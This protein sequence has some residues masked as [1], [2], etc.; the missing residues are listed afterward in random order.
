MI[1]TNDSL[2]VKEIL[3]AAGPFI[4]SVIDT[5]VTPKLENL[6]KRFSQDYNKYHVPTEEHFSEYFYRTYK[7]VSIINTLVFNNSQRF[8]KDI[9]LPLTLI[10][11]TEKK[12]IKYKMN[13][14]PSHLL[15]NYEKLLIT[16]NAGMGKSTLVKKCF[17][18]Q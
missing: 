1:E 2:P 11:K 12:E 4:K 14:F 15:N 13:S 9:Y 18:T 7:R 10:Q 6:K 5:Y 3:T 16:D 17:L 8:I